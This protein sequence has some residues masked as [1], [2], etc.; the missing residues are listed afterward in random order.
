MKQ[1]VHLTCG[2]RFE[3]LIVP[4][5][6]NKR[7]G[8]SNLSISNLPVNFKPPVDFSAQKLLNLFLFFACSVT[9]IT[10]L[11]KGQDMGMA[12]DLENTLIT[13]NEQAEWTTQI[14]SAAVWST[15]IGRGM[16]RLGSH[17]SRAS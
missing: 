13:F 15:L 1:I 10:T 12:K 7:A 4:L 3:I 5:Y 6:A 11:I 8:I 17:W 2:M 9:K 14:H 16:S